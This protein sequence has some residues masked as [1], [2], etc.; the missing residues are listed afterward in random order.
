MLSYMATKTTVYLDPAD[1]ENLRRMARER[2][3]SAAL[4]IREAIAE[5]TASRAQPRKPASVA[6]GR[7]GRND[8]GSNAEKYLKGFGRSK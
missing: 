1:Y 3:T 7:S 5:Y 2:G 6:M 4:L 8:L